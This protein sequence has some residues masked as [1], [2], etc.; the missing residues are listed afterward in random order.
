MD[1]DYFSFNKPALYI[2]SKEFETT[3]MFFLFSYNIFYYL[4]NYFLPIPGLPVILL[5]YKTNGM[6]GGFVS[7]VGGAISTLFFF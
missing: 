1:I 4:I 3:I 5:N 6:L 2:P 7:T